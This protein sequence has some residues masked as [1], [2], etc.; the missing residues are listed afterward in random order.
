MLRVDR[1]TFMMFC[2]I[3]CLQRRFNSRTKDRL[4]LRVLC[5]RNF[6]KVIATKKSFWCRLQKGVKRLP[7]LLILSRV[8]YTF[9]PAAENRKKKYLKAVKISS[10]PLPVTYILGW[11][12]HEINQKEWVNPELKAV[13]VLPRPSPITYTLSSKKGMSLNKRYCCLWG[14]LV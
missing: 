3:R 4:S 1:W 2:Q 7:S 9:L 12:Q 5:N 11:H 8:L 10:R 6:V 14:L 13:E